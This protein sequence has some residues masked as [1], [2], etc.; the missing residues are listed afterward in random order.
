MR[1][2]KIFIPFFLFGL[3]L[4][5]GQSCR[6]DRLAAWVVR[7]DIDTP[8][9][10]EAI[11]R[12][13]RQADLDRL[14][15]QVRGRADAYYET[16]LAPRAEDLPP[17][18]DALAEVLTACRDVE[19]DAWLNVYYLWTGEQPPQNRHHP[20]H[21]K[22]WLLKDQQ[23]RRVDSYSPLEQSQRWIEGIYAD[24]A[25]IEYR[26]YFSAVVAE[27]VQRYAVGGIHLDFVRYP[28][29]SFGAGGR[30]AREFQEQY[31]VAVSDLPVRLTRQDFAAWLNG[32]LPEKK[33]RLVMA[34]LLWDHRRAAEVT[35]LVGMVR[36]VLDEVNPD[37][38][39]SASV[40]ADPV[41]SFLDK[42]QDW[43]HWLAAGLVD[44]LYIMNYFG[45]KERVQGLYNEVVELVGG[46]DKLWL[47]LGSYIKSAEEVGRERALCGGG[48]QA[49]CF[50]SLGHFLRQGKAVRAYVEAVGGQA[51]QTDTDGDGGSNSA[52]VRALEELKA[53]LA[54][55]TV[56]SCAEGMGSVASDSG[57]A[58]ADGGG[59]RGDSWL[60]LRGIFRYVNHYDSLDKVAEQLDLAR[61]SRRLL[62][63]GQ[64]FVRVARQFSQAGSRHHGGILPRRYLDMDNHVDKILARLAPG[65]ISP[66]LA[67]HN[68]FWVYQVVAKG[69]GYRVSDQ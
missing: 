38:R 13:A 51:G 52:P 22:G 29:A 59:T 21:V 30:L 68:G 14:L 9:E 2:F 45:D 18:F 33:N 40:F 8:E 11:C 65:Q 46:R 55:P 1:F 60:E 49:A 61:Q 56:E 62:K 5:A 24:P 44:E 34:R 58:A 4:L 53:C 48:E 3:L 25:S 17:D 43:S 31:G 37:I 64:P 26:R 41:E 63:A 16:S 35:R 23:G 50:F 27:L 7:F 66:V 32:S 10:V 28:G 57:E 67:V 6:A 20:A 19:V 54:G 69:G 47:G 36:A 12:Q 42:G 15:V 39:L